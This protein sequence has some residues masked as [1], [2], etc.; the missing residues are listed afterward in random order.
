MSSIAML[1]L[2]PAALPYRVSSTDLSNP[3]GK[4]HRVNDDGTIPG[5]NPFVNTPNAVPSIWSYGHRN[6]QGLAW[7]PIGPALGNGAWAHGRRRGQYHRAR[8]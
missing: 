2:P 6:P 3:L 5:D 4:I 1:A 8:T 7:D